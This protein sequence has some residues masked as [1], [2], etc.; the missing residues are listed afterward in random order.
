V[1][2]LVDT[3][4]VLTN[5]SHGIRYINS[6][7]KVLYND[8]V[9]VYQETSDKFPSSNLM[10][11]DDLEHWYVNNEETIE[12]D[13]FDGM[14]LNITMPVITAQVDYTNTGWKIGTA[15]ISVIPT[16]DVY[17]YFP[18][19][20]DIIFTDD[21]SAYVSVTNPTAILDETRTRINKSNVFIP[22]GVQF[23]RR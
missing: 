20:Y 7:F 11:D 2:F 6:G 12:T 15:P 5:Y 17:Q 4:E 16:S 19:D 22:A 9:V 8:S 18:W 10:Y 21:D 14:R 13:V 1:N 23:L 3:L